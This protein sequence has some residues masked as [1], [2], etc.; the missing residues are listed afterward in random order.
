MGKLIVNGL[1]SIIKKLSAEP[2]QKFTEEERDEIV[3][4]INDAMDN[5]ELEAIAREKKSI[6][7][8]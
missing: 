6:Q 5:F 3:S 2:E 4:R 7:E 8:L 1:D